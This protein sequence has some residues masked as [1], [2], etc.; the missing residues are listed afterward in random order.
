[1]ALGPRTRGGQ[2]GK[3]GHSNMAHYEHTEEIKLAH[4]KHL[5]QDS[6]KATREVD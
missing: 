5:R 6:K 3:K 4:K 2:G 1:M